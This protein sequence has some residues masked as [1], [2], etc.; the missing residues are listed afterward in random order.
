[1]NGKF[2]PYFSEDWPAPSNENVAYIPVRVTKEPRVNGSI[3]V[4]LPD[5]TALDARAA[6]LLRL[7]LDPSVRAGALAA[8]TG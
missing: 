5:G 1:M 3:T 7:D 8:K 2:R 4:F 6:D